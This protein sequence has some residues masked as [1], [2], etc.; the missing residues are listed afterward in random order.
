MESVPGLVPEMPD[1]GELGRDAHHCGQSSRT[2]CPNHPAPGVGEGGK[3][4][5]LRVSPREGLWAGRRHHG[6]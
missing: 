1:L 3:I 6:Q 4:A 2:L 5:L